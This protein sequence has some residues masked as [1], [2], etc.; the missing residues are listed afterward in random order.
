[1][2][3]Y[4]I[5]SI[6]IVNL[7]SREWDY[8][9]DI[10]EKGF[11]DGNEVRIF[12]SKNPLDQNV[13]ISSDTISIF[14]QK[15]KQY[16]DSKKLILTGS[17]L[18]INGNDSLECDNMIFWYGSQKDSLKAI[19]EVNFK[20]QNNL[21]NTDK[22]SYYET[23]GFRGYSFSTDGN[24]TLIDPKY[25]IKAEQIIYDDDYQEMELI[26]N[27]NVN[28]ENQ[29]VMGNNIDLIFADSLI[30]KI[31]VQDNGYVFNNHYAIANNK[32][33]QIFKDEMYGN[34][35]EINLNAGI[36]DSILI[37]GM[38]KSIYYVVN[39][40]NNLMGYNEATGNAIKLYYKNG[41]LNTLNIIGDAR[42]VFYPEIGQTKL[43]S[44]L[45]YKAS[46]IDY[47]VTNELTRL[48]ENV[49]IEYQMT[50][51]KS[52]NVKIDWNSNNL[53]A[54]SNEEE[55]SE[56]VNQ[57]QKPIVGDN[58]EFDLINKKGVIQLGETVVG[59]GIYKSNT[60]HRQEPN[61]Y[62]MN[63]S[64]YTTCEHGHPHYYFKTPKMKMIQGE[65][66]IAKPL[67]LYI[68]DIPI[69]GIPFA[70]LPNKSSNRQT[71]WIM[72][73]FGVSQSKGTYFQKLGYYWAPSDYSDLRLL[74]D[75][76]DRD[77]I[78]LRGKLRYTK[79]Y[80]F[81]GNLSTTFKRALKTQLTDDM[82]DL[83]TNKS[84][85]NFDIKWIHKQ[86]IDPTQ[87]FNINWTYV[88]SSDFY[89]EFGYDLN[90]R[91]QQRLE[92]SANYNKIW[93]KFNNRFS[94][95][96]SESYDLNNEREIPIIS[97]N[98]D[99]I[100]QYYKSRTLPYMKFS[101][102][103]SKIFGNGDKWY[104][105]IYYG[106]SSRLNGLQTIG[107]ISNM[108]DP[109]NFSWD[110]D[111]IEYNSNIVHN[112]NISAPNKLFGWLTL[113][114]RINLKEGW[115]F[116]YNNNGNTKKGFKRRLTGDMSLSASSIL[117]GLFPIN[118]FKIDAIRHIM[119]PSI[120]FSYTPDFSKPILGL[121]LGYF[122][123]EGNDYFL[124][125]MIGTTPNSET[126]RMGLNIR[127]NFQ[128]KLNDSTNTK[129]DFLT[130]NLSTGYNFKSDIKIDPIS[131]RIVVSIPNAIDINVRMYHDPYQLDNNTLARTNQLAQFPIL[132][133]IQAETDISLSGQKSL[134]SNDIESDTIQRDEKN[135]LFNSN[136]FFEPNINDNTIWDLDLRLGMKLQK[137]IINEDTG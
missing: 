41:D 54:F 124:N 112:L 123:D 80:E 134:I 126:K 90:T 73:S 102:S 26:L 117:Y 137:K 63:K 53:Y 64:I 109:E 116:K 29:G 44:I 58:L 75:F 70:I 131:S 46:I 121:D 16:I 103:N 6:L 74:A 113:N 135:S 4:I 84:T 19:G 66:I 101:H 36:I 42:G 94:L 87:N 55:K 22:L 21:L 59:D 72:P 35:L 12:K 68:Y 129:M 111:T 62:H 69:L 85:R 97:E 98:D 37:N 89:N 128:L 34:D 1:M 100:I 82:S 24:S 31:S 105:S 127:N 10:L 43:D 93:K 118:N 5:I 108:P 27:A 52:N 32:Q 83:F 50:K 65:R 92:S 79:R 2:K 23:N 81:T 38:A 115:I 11:E 132:T 20:F 49:E 40:E 3:Y 45:N 104:N 136:N 30:K 9:A 76:Y 56:I 125:S 47:D 18:M 61:I 110:K 88:T 99:L 114:P 14:T 8:S 71:G 51:L 25:N 86:T 96:V 120:S 78:E 91:T 17:V 106:F 107:H 48:Y 77:R 60:I 67:F 28:S 95:S 57:N 7:F 15:A 130:W 13:I 33:Y 119:S 122:D 133:Y 39:E